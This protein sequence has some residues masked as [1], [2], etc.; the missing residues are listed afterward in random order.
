MSDV[1]AR[2]ARTLTHRWRR[3]LVV[4]LAALVVLGAFAAN[5]EPAS[6]DFNVPGS[7]SQM[8][9]DLLKAHTPALAGADS[10]LVFTA[11]DGKVSDP[12]NRAA[13]ESALARVAELDGGSG[14]VSPFDAGGP[15]SRGGPDAQTPVQVGLPAMEAQ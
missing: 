12:E 15:I 2:L 13:V 7:E 9:V 5:G 10:Q 8:A 3:S 4:A 1:L 14:V 6:D 11:T